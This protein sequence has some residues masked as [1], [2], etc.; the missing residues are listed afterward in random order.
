M[1]E[2]RELTGVTGKDDPADSLATDSTIAYLSE[3][4]DVNLENAELFV[5]MEIV[6]APAVGQINRTGFVEGW[7]AAKYVFQDSL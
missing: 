3:K 5:A 2:S 7:K 6:Q 4:L 1:T